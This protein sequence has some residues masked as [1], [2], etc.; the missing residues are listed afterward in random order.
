MAAD[1]PLAKDLIPIQVYPREMSRD[2][3]NWIV[4]EAWWADI[5]PLRQT[6]GK[7]GVPA[8]PAIQDEEQP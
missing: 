5:H 6:H 4:C 1:L 2:S 8:L 7:N 3:W